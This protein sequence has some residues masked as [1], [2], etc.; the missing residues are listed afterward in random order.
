MLTI[1]VVT[2]NPIVHLT[3]VPHHGIFHF[4]I[5]N[6]L[7]VIEM[8]KTR[9]FV[10]V[11]GTLFLLA[12]AHTSAFA[13]GVAGKQQSDD[14]VVYT[15]KVDA[16]HSSI[17]FKVRHLGIVN[18]N[19]A[20]SSYEVQLAMNPDDLS[21]LRTDVSVDVMSVDTGIEKRDN[22][23]RSADFFSAEAFPTMKF[24][25]K[26]VRNVDGSAFDLVGDLTIRGVTKEVVLSGELVGSVVGPMGQ[27]RV[28]LEAAGTINRGDFGLVWNNLTEAGG[29]IVS[30]EVKILIEVQA[31]QS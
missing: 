13:D 14:P 15:Y 5:R 17:S 11:L 26:E 18:V 22:H 30:D 1:L 4:R 12:S 23:L 10:A 8:N 3:V 27:P 20:F 25:S 16:A 7:Q 9:S 19:G 24:V 6:S 21:T 31:I 28:G 29:V 2:N